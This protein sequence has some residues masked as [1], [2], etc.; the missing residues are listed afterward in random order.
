[1]SQKKKRLLA[2]AGAALFVVLM[3]LFGIYAKDLLSDA[4]RFAGW[5]RGMGLAGEGIMVL[6]VIAQVLLAVVPGGPFQIAAGYVYGPVHGT[7]LCVL[8]STLGSMITFLLVRKYG[9]PV[10][11]L[12]CGE[13][14]MKTLD[15]ITSSPRWKVILPLIFLIPGTPKD[16]LSYAA[17]LTDLPIPVWILIA[18]L[19]RLPAIVLSA[20]SGNA[21]QE[22]DYGKAVGVLVLICV[23]SAVGGL[24]YRKYVLNAPEKPAE[25]QVQE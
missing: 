7:L 21:V 1:M 10:I 5:L 6:L 2:L 4:D 14:Q 17:G 8:G 11:A 9:R 24:L 3:V 13:S 25:P 16:L 18:S 12:F 19:G 15:R 20:I 22:A 23:I